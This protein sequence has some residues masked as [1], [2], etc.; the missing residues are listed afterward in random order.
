MHYILTVRV[1]GLTILNSDCDVDIQT[2]SVLT[3]ELHTVTKW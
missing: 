1:R 3:P 2:V